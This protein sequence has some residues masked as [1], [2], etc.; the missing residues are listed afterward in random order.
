V[1]GLGQ[2]FSVRLYFFLL[3]VVLAACSTSPRQPAPAAAVIPS[4]PAPPVTPSTFKKFRLTLDEFWRLERPEVRPFEAS[5]LVFH[6]GALLT[7]SDKEFGLYRI[8][9]GASNVARLERTAFFNSEQLQQLSPSPGTDFE[10]LTRDDQGRLYACEEGRRCILRCDPASK[11]VERLN[12]D[13][14]PVRQYFNPHPNASFEGVAIIGRKL[15]VA[16]ERDR[17][18]II[19]VD[20]DTLKV[21]G[22]F[23]TTPSGPFL[24]LH[25]SDLA[26]HNG[27]L[28]LLLRHQRLILE[29]DPLSRKALAEYDFM[30]I[31]EAPEHQYAKEYPTGAMEGLAVDDD[32]FWL[33]TDN[34]GLPR[35]RNAQDRRP[36]LFRCRRP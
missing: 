30:G 32:Y 17:A 27:H 36:T 2:F 23:Q 1:A 12:I 19:E 31:E 7:M 29:V 21:V 8:V 24:F 10:G 35:R 6:E 13:W 9:P 5:G 11:K 22:D 18:R 33:V 34:N 3:V 26:A 28:F 20:L 4:A 16:N 14:A 15:W 25:Y